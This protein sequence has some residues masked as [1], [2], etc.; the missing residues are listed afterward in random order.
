MTEVSWTQLKSF[1]DGRSLA[2]QYIEFDDSYYLSAFDGPFSLYTHISKEDP[3]PVDSDQEDFEDNYKADANK[4]PTTQV[5]TRTERGDVSMKLCRISKATSSGSAD[6]EIKVPG[7]YGTDPGRMIAG[8][9]GCFGTGALGDYI[10]EINVVDKDN[11]TG[12]G[13]NTIVKKWHDEDVTSYQSK[14]M[15]LMPGL[16]LIDSMGDWGEL[17]AGLYLQIK[18][19]KASGDDT[20]YLNII[21][22]EVNG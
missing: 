6:V 7:T 12:L 14:G 4:P 5:Q 8:G 20:F 21:W 17:P 1:V 10:S 15:Y 18:V 19:N 16:N 11:V 13:A 22:G 9:S 3:A 2:L